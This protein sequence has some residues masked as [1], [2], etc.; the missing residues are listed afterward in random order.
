MKTFMPRCS[1][2]LH[3]KHREDLLMDDVT[4]QEGQ[5]FGDGMPASPPADVIT[6][7]F[8][9]ETRTP[10]AAAPETSW[11]FAEDQGSLVNAGFTVELRN[12]KTAMVIAPN[13]PI[14]ITVEGLLLSHRLMPLAA[15]M[16]VILAADDREVVRERFFLPTPRRAE[17]MAAHRELAQI[18]SDFL[19]DSRMRDTAM[20]VYF[21]E[22]S[23]EHDLWYRISIDEEGILAYKLHVGPSNSQDVKKCIE[24]TIQL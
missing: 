4:M 12:V 24:G 10:E 23:E 16:E 11:Q 2:S 14:P 20:S 3:P 1:R 9:V 7:D 18:C 17:V 13:H 15:E 8:P 6:D 21:P 5:E 19:H 22:L